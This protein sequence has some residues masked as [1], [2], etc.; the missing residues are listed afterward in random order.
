MTGAELL[1]TTLTESSMAGATATVAAH[2][3]SSHCTKAGPCSFHA[4]LLLPD[5]LVTNLDTESRMADA[6]S[7]PRPCVILSLK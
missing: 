4:A 2:T 3:E 1:P 7:E 6:V 5:P